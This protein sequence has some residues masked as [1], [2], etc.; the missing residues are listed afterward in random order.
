MTRT[1][2]ADPAALSEA[3]KD[4]VLTRGRLLRAGMSETTIAA[5]CQPGGPWRRLLPGVILLD[6]SEPTRRQQLCAAVAKTGGGTVITGADALR[7]LGVNLP[8]T[9]AV[10]VLVP[11]GNR[12]ASRGFM[13]LE[14]TSRM[15]EPVYVDD[16]P[17]APPERA[18]IDAARQESH[19]D[20]LRRLLSLPVYYGLC[21]A[22]Q[23]RAELD[24]GNQRGSAAARG[25]LRALGS[26]G[27][28]FVHGLARALLRRAPLPPPS[29]NVRICDRNGKPIGHADAWWD[30]IAF[31]WQFGG[32]GPIE[33]AMGPLA[34]TAAGVMLVRTPPERLRNDGDTVVKELVSAFR[35]A[36]G[37]TR[38]S[39]QAVGLEAAA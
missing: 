39:I 8:V 17:F 12:M 23:L 27:D 19:P 30:E 1:T 2:L 5:R 10:Q 29:W 20:R 26:M 24:T 3:A 33:A 38:P 6:S 4:G 35:T 7:A 32:R 22:G 15:P 18:A 36:T 25:M 16:L 31:G 37:R 11:A 21:T 34:L 28:T 13:N 14:R 9:R